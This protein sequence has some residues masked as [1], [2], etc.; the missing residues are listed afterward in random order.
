MGDKKSLY[1]LEEL[2][3]KT[4]TGKIIQIQTGKD[5]LDWFCNFTFSALWRPRSPRHFF[6]LWPSEISIRSYKGISIQHRRKGGVRAWKPIQREEI[7]LEHRGYPVRSCIS[8]ARCP[9]E[10]ET[11][12]PCYSPNIFKDNR[13]CPGGTYSQKHKDQWPTGYLSISTFDML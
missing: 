4:I 2:V 9:P 5:S 12:F 10:T 3:R 7:P 1:L 11:E 6:C 13:W 8:L